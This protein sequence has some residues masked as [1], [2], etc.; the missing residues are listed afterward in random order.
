MNTKLSR[1]RTRLKRINKPSLVIAILNTKGLVMTRQYANTAYCVSY[2]KHFD[3]KHAL[4]GF[5]LT[6]FYL[7]YYFREFNDDFQMSTFSLI[8]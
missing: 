4:R 6:H 7:S 2:L 5:K 1:Q 3:S 8:I